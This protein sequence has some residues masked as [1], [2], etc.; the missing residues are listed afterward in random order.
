M[1]N[2]TAMA[3]AGSAAGVTLACLYVKL[4]QS[5][6]EDDVALQVPSEAQIVLG[7]RSDIIA[8][9]KRRLV[10]DKQDRLGDLIS[11]LTHARASEPEADDADSDS[12]WVDIEDE[13]DDDLPPGLD[14]PGYDNDVDDEDAE[15]EIQKLLAN[16]AFLDE[17]MQQEAERMQT[18][19]RPKKRK[20][21][22]ASKKKH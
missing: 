8:N 1:K 15:D 20:P 22:L 12:G 6:D 2:A 7:P 5:D 16:P 14:G 18:V 9:E 11:S 10:E 3:I 21:K 19:S 17:L 4:R 13:T